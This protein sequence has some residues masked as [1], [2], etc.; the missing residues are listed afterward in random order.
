VK[1][2]INKIESLKEIAPLIAAVQIRDI[3]LVEAGVS[4]SVRSATEAGE[5]K[6]EVATSADVKEYN[7]DEGIFWVLAQIKI[8]L[9]PV[10]PEKDAVVSV[11]AAFEIK[12]SLPKE[13]RA[14]Q[15]QLNTFA[16][17]NGVFNAWPY[18]REFVQN[19]VAR[20]NL[21]TIT[22]P[23][24]RLEDTTKIRRKKPD[25]NIR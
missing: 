17:I 7:K 10:E 5:I 19:M 24:F 9:I 21:P 25:K 4:T 2:Q 14:S 23:V 20:M 12:Y 15:K 6:F 1:R 13:L 8:R 22:L 3:R 18:W 11:S 16:R